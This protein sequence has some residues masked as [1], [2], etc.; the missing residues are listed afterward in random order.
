MSPIVSVIIPWRQRNGDLF[1]QMNLK[2][3]EDFWIRKHGIV[4]RRVSD[5]REG[6][7]QFNRS[8]AYNHGVRI[9]PVA[10]VFVFAEADMLIEPMQLS[11][12]VL[13]AAEQ[14]GLV[15]PFDEYRYLSE[16]NSEMVRSAGL[17]PV[18]VK[19]RWTMDNGRSIGAVNVVSRATMD[20]V[21]QWDES[22]EGNSYDDDAMKIAFE[23]AAGRTRW[24]E[25]PAHHLYHLPG[26]RGKHLTPQD[27]RA[28]ERNRQR[29]ELYREAQ[30]PEQIRRLTMGER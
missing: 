30:T 26:W 10:N 21:G 13:L 18:E 29:R 6:S 25:G 17:S 20:L 11:K 19:A 7:A 5:G 24:V 15:V 9:S 23:K 8:A 1:R 4:P 16:A 27:K 14:P 12:A 3:V 28:T 2:Y 22:F